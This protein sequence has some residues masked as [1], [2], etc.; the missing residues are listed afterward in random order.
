MK[1][2][3]RLTCDEWGRA[4]LTADARMK[5]ANGHV[6]VHT[7]KTRCQYCGRKPG[8]KTRCAGWFQAFLYHLDIVILNLDREPNVRG[9]HF[10][11]ADR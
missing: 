1:D 3:I 9:Q 10:T 8:V 4:K 11:E 7:L 6:F 5:A 2:E